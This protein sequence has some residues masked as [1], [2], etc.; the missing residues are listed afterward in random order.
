MD[1]AWH[2]TNVSVTM[3][4]LEQ[5]A[6]FLTALMSISVPEKESVLPA[7]CVAVTRDL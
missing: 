5:A 7:T 1:A 3:A 2:S 4:G 6:G